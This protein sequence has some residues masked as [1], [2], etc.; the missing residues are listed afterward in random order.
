VQRMAGSKERMC[1]TVLRVMMA[2]DHISD[3]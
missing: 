2:G 1:D 3:I